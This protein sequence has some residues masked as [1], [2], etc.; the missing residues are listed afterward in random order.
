[1]TDWSCKDTCIW[2]SLK[3]AVRTYLFKIRKHLELSSVNDLF[4]SL[5]C[6]SA[7]AFWS[8][9]NTFRYV[10]HWKYSYVNQKKNPSKAGGWFKLLKNTRLFSSLNIIV[11]VL[12]NSLEFCFWVWAVT[13]SLTELCAVASVLWL[14][15]QNGVFQSQPTPGKLQ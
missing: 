8:H 5:W 3:A 11:V 4:S 9:Y 1:M 12:S 2:K 10:Q 13:E 7:I 14:V 6:I 15:L